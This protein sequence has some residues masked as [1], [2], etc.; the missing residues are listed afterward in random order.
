MAEAIEVGEPGASINPKKSIPKA[1]NSPL[2]AF[3][4]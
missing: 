3:F 4:I 2:S 1:D